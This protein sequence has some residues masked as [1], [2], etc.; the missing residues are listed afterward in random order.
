MQKLSGD[1]NPQK[2]PVDK[3]LSNPVSDPGVQDSQQAKT[4]PASETLSYVRL[5]NSKDIS[6]ALVK[7]QKTVTP[8][9]KQILTTMLLYGVETVDEIEKAYLCTRHCES[10]AIRAKGKKPTW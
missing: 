6:D 2:I 5:L 3:P 4:P 7:L 9:N 8:Q 1:M 10:S